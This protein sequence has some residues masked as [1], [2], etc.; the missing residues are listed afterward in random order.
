MISHCKLCVTTEIIRNIQQQ[1]SNCIGGGCHVTNRR[2][3]RLTFLPLPQFPPAP[4]F[5]PSRSPPCLSLP[6]SPSGFW[7]TFS[8]IITVRMFSCCGYATKHLANISHG[9]RWE[10]INYTKKY[11]FFTRRVRNRMKTHVWTFVKARL[12]TSHIFGNAPDSCMR[13]D[14]FPGDRFPSTLGI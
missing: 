6:L 7:P 2:P 14:I 12:G 1:A 5:S 9:V 3:E 8:N 4:S 11:F 13:A 10:S